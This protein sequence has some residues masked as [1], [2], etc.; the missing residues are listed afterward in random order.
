MARTAIHGLAA[1][2]LLAGAAASADTLLVERLARD[3]D[4]AAPVR[5]GESMDRIEARLGD[6]LKRNPAVCEPPITRWDY[7]GFSVFFEHSHV[8]HAVRHP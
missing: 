2:L 8:I 7:D 6:P 3:A 5:R 4:A 1:L